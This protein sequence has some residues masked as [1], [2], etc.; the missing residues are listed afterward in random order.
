MYFNGNLRIVMGKLRAILLKLRK[1]QP[2]FYSAIHNAWFRRKFRKNRKQIFGKNNKITKGNAVLN[3]VTFDI[4]GDHNHIDIDSMAVLDT[5]TFHV[6]GDS[7]RALIGADCRIANSTIWIENNMCE[8]IVGRQTTVG[9]MHLAATEEH[10]K[11]VIGNDCMLA[12]DIDI[13]TGD[14]HGIYDKYGNRLNKAQDVVMGD[15]VWVAA[16]SI[17]LKGSTIGEGS[18][19]ATGAVVPKGVYPANCILAGN[20]A[21]P[22]KQNIH[23]SRS[24]TDQSWRP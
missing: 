17:I 10:S 21:I 24:R 3:G 1:S 20:P 5:V 2:R 13:R 18:V 12:Y 19:I 16:H 14:S 15:H 22:V 9:G 4:E 6:R 7:N 11:V 23:W 8:V